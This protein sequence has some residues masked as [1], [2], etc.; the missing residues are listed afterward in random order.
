MANRWVLMVLLEIAAGNK[1]ACPT[2]TST[3]QVRLRSMPEQQCQKHDEVETLTNIRRNNKRVLGQQPWSLAQLVLDELHLLSYHYLS[4]IKSVCNGGPYAVD[5]VQ[6]VPVNNLLPL[7]SPWTYGYVRSLMDGW[8]D[9]DV[10]WNTFEV[11]LTGPVGR[12]VGKSALILVDVHV[13]HHVEGNLLRY[14][15]YENYSVPAPPTSVASISSFSHNPNIGRYY[16]VLFSLHN[17]AACDR[18][19]SSFSLF[20][21]A[22][23]KIIPL[24]SSSRLTIG[25]VG[26]GVAGLYAALL[27][28]RAGHIV[29]IFEGSDRLGGRVHTHYF[30]EEENQY[31]EAG[32]MR[33][34]HSPYQTDVKASFQDRSAEELMLAAVGPLLQRLEGNFVEGFDEI[35]R[36]YDNYSFRFYLSHVLN[37]PNDI[38]DFVETVTS[39]TNQFCLSVTEIMMEYIDFSTKEWSTIAH[40]MSRLPLAMAHLIGYKNIT[41]NARV[42]GIRSEDDGKVTISVF[43]HKSNVEATFDKVIMAIPPPALKMITDRPAWSPHKELAIRSIHFE[44]LFK[45]GLRFKTR[46][47]ERVGPTSCFGGQSTTDL[48]IRWIVYPSNG[49]GSD[50]PGVLLIY[51]WMT[52]ADAWLPLTPEERQNLAL[53]NL[54][55]VYNGQIDTKDGSVINVYD[56]IM[57]TSDAVWSARNSTGD[58]MFLPGQFLSRFEAARHPEGNV[59]FAG[60]HLSRHHT[61]IAGA[62]ESAW[63]TVSNIIGP[64]PQLC[65]SEVE[66]G[67]LVEIDPQD[68]IRRPV[69]TDD[70]APVLGD[71]ASPMG[72]RG[73]GEQANFSIDFILRLHEPPF[74]FDT[75]WWP[76]LQSSNHKNCDGNTNTLPYHPGVHKAQRRGESEIR[77]SAEIAHLEPPKY[78]VSSTSNGYAYCDYTSPLLRKVPL[79]GSTRMNVPKYSHVHERNS[80]IARECVEV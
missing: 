77:K 51:S 55:E 6:G 79:K 7:R 48:P 21:S 42:T 11:G 24:M 5:K 67:S 53:A 69:S 73:G 2:P 29:H 32:A 30:T 26:G 3:S 65:P 25:I 4:G 64:T 47:W 17:V 16:A 74:G 9:E 68:G 70:A 8:M 62:L 43:G 19:F 28:Q 15:H 31:Y 18:E 33:I 36:E 59:Y 46:F 80:V 22:Q 12:E 45:M 35:C 20:T 54:A 49:I 1:L 72:V 50:G 41:L 66:V 63:E 23:S 57:D 44:S 60:E 75:Q 37:W 56:L 34:P 14:F 27:L 40:G 52:D 39:Q 78:F 38:I 58:A 76:V 13:H 61:W 71:D 10:R